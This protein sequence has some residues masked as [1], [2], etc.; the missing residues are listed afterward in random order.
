MGNDSVSPTRTAT[1]FRVLV[2]PKS[3]DDLNR[4]R[5]LIPEAVETVF[6]GRT[7]LQA[8]LYDSRSQAQ[9]VLDRLLDAGFEAVAEMI[10]R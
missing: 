3:S 5:Q 8:G 10:F 2:T 6:N 4:L 1:Q 7:V 9:S